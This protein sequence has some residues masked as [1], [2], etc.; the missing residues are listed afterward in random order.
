MTTILLVRHGRTEWNATGRLQGWAGVPLDATGRAQAT[1]LA[2]R[3][4]GRSI[5]ALVSSDL[6]RASETAA[7]LG[8]TLGLAPILDAAWRERDC[9][10]LVGGRHPCP[11]DAP[12]SSCPPGGE[13]IERLRDRVSTALGDLIAA[14]RDRTVLVVTHGRALLVLVAHVLG[15]PFDAPSPLAP[16]ANTS[17]SI[18]EVEAG[19]P[20]LR[21][22]NDAGHLA[23]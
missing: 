10:P 9:G 15:L 23:P 1:A 8:R 16:A 18:L 12:L 22:Y 4:A 20:R 6:V 13:S 17:L 2:E 14:H 5:D 11:P 21:L 19:R 7:I 3:L